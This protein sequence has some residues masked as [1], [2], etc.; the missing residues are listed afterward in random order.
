MVIGA[1]GGDW[2]DGGILIQ[3]HQHTWDATNGMFNNSWNQAYGGINTC[4][5]LLAG[6]LD[7]NGEAQIRALRAYFYF[8]LMDLFGN[9][10]IITAPGSDAP[11]SSRAE[12]VNFV[13]S[14]L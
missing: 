1:K 12:V 4:N 14:E 9:V 11:Q 7:A 13:E 8:R 6:G 10:K 3:L 2:F 5:E